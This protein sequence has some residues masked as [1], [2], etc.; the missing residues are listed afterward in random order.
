MLNI[1]GITIE[2]GL[3]NIANTAL[4]DYKKILKILN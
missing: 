3:K 2:A 1:F 4:M